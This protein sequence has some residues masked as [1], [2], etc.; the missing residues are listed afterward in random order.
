MHSR[1]AMIT[2]ESVL[3][4]RAMLNVECPLAGMRE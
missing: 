3:L 1:F 4:R 2:D